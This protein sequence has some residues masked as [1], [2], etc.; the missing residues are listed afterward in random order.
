[1]GKSGQ[2]SELLQPAA[3][4]N[5][6]GVYDSDRAAAEALT[7]GYWQIS[8]SQVIPGHPAHTHLLLL[9]LYYTKILVLI[10]S[11]SY[12]ISTHTSV[13]DVIIFFM[14]LFFVFFLAIGIIP[15]FEYY[16]FTNM[17]PPFTYASMIRWVSTAELNILY[18]TFFHF[19]PVT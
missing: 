13:Y 1:M 7:Q 6:N 8:T 4:Q 12:F 17:R 3:C 14:H 15:S 5:A 11:R 19:L 16:K 9:K 2:L 10:T 18:I